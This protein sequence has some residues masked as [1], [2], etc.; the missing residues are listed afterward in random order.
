ITALALTLGVFPLRPAI[1]LGFG[2]TG[3]FLTAV[4]LRLVGD[5]RY[6]TLNE[7]WSAHRQQTQVVDQVQGLANALKRVMLRDTHN[8]A[9]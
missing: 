2:L 9:P 8:H 1:A 5:S 4:G 6:C 7:R 3:S